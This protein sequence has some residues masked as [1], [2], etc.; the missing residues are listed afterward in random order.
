M[1]YQFVLWIIST[2]ETITNI[3]IIIISVMNLLLI[4][5]IIIMERCL[6]QDNGFRF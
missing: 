4:I 3:I 2:T 1:H 6:N 5:F